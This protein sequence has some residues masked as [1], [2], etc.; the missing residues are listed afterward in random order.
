MQTG[1]VEITWPHTFTVCVIVNNW[2]TYRKS[3]EYFSRAGFS[4]ANSEFVTVDNTAGNSTD[5]FKAIRMFLQTA[6][7]RYVV[8]AHQDAYPLQPC[9]ILSDRLNLL[10]QQDPM[11]GVAGNAGVT[12]ESWPRQIGSLQMPSASLSMSEPFKRVLVLDENVLIIRNGSGVTVSADLEGY[13]FYGLDACLVAARLGFNSYVLDYL[14]RHD[15]EGTIGSDFLSSKHKLQAKLRAYCSSES[16]PTAC[17]YVC[18]SRHLWERA[19]SSSRSFLQVF[20]QK[21]L[22]E[23]R[24]LLWKEGLRNPLFVP[25]LCVAVIGLASKLAVVKLQHMSRTVENCKADIP[26]DAPHSP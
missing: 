11:W 25:A 22:E 12:R 6:H 2:K 7:G 24:R 5:A 20:P 26:A 17:T 3:R 18:W 8:V 9:Q 19:L 21:R 16:L 4:D 15:S 10:E 14:W 23:A 13:H 1:L